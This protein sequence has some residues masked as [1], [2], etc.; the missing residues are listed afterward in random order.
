MR[1]GRGFPR[2]CRAKNGRPARR[3]KTRACSWK[4]C[5]GGPDTA[6]R[7]ARFARQ[8][9][10]PLAHGVRPVSALAPSR[11]VA[12]GTVPSAKRD[13]LAPAHGGLDGRPR[14]SGG[15]RREKKDSPVGQALGR[16]RGG[17]TTKLPLSCDA[18]GRICALALTGG[19]AGVGPHVLAQVQNATGLHRLRVDSTAVRAHQVA[20]GAKKKTAP[21][22]RR[23]V[24]VGVVPGRAVSRLSST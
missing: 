23:S 20:A 5:S 7:G 8:T 11:G 3:P 19:Q 2:C 10:R 9:V 13:G 24:A 18:H 16:S 14:A 15:R 21:S 6:C 12:A 1:N 4:R 22:G 17:F